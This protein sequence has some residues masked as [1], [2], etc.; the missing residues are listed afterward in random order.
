M[1]RELDG[2]LDKLTK[3]NNEMG[4]EE[5]RKKKGRDGGDRFHN[6]KTQVAERLHRLKFVSQALIFCACNLQDPEQQSAKRN[7]HP[8]EAIRRQQEIREDIR[9]VGQDIEELETSYEQELKK[10]KSKFPPAELQIRKE[11]VEQYSSEFAF[12]KELATAGYRAPGAGRSS[13]DRTEV[14]STVGNFEGSAFFTGG[15]GHGGGGGGYVGGG[16]SGEGG[17]GPGQEEVTDEQRE[18]MVQIKHN[19][20]RFDMM[21][22]QIG[23]GVQELGQLARGLNEEL[24]QQSIMIDGLEE[25]IDTTQ[26]HGTQRIN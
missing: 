12:I 22:E 11:I 18:V 13:F 1:S 25:R 4:G 17:D 14:A 20:Q 24:Q 23:S 26:A 9:L 10:K 5:G 6:L 8:R 2:L 16:G 7:K 19:D 3:I 15:H 21:I